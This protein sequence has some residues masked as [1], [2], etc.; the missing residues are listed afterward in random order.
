V[1]SASAEVKMPAN[2]EAVL[3]TTSPMVETER[4]AAVAAP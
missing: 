3:E 1:V 4:L 2:V